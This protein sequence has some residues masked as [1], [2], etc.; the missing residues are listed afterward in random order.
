MNDCCFP[1]PSRMALILLGS[2]LSFLACKSQRDS[3][4]DEFWVVEHHP[5]RVQLV[6]DSLDLTYPGLEG[7]RSYVERQAWPQ[8]CR[9]LCD[10]YSALPETDWRISYTRN[11]PWDSQAP[12]AAQQ[13]LKDTIV[14]Q[15]RQGTLRRD[16]QQRIDWH[17]LGPAEDK[18]WAWFVN[19]FYFLRPIISAYVETQGDQYA[20]FADR[21]IRDWITQ[22]PMPSQKTGNATWRVLEVGLRMVQTWPYVFYSLR[23][24]E[25]FSVGSRMLFLASIVEHASYLRKHHWY[26]HNHS[27]MEMNGLATIALLW[28]E[29]Q[30][31]ELWYQHAETQILDDL[32]FLMYPDGAEIELSS[33]YHRVALLH[34]EDFFSL[35]QQA[36]KPTNATIEA[37]LENMWSYLAYT[38]RPNGKGL[39]NN[40]SDLDNNTPRLL[41]AAKT[42]QR[43]DWTYLMTQGK[44]GTQP[45]TEP[46]TYFE[47]A[48]H[49]ISRNNWSP[50]A[51]WAFFDVGCWGWSH[52]H[53]DKLHLSIHAYGRDLLVDGGRYWYKNPHGSDTEKGRSPHFWRGYFLHS[54]SHNTIL[55]DGQGQ[56]PPPERIKLE[57]PLASSLA[58]ITPTY[59]LAK[60]LHEEGYW[61]VEGEITHERTLVYLPDQAWL[62]IDR[63]QTD[64]ER[65]LEV[66]WHFHPDCRVEPSGSTFGSTD[67]GKGNLRIIPSEGREW[68]T[69]LIV[70]QE[71]PTIQGWYSERYNEKHPNPTVVYR[72]STTTATTF[73]W[74]LLPAKGSVGMA[75]LVLSPETDDRVTAH[76][77]FLESGASLNLTVDLVEG[78]V[79]FFD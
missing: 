3:P 52:Q 60:G 48:G 4:F 37:A 30:A 1:L 8:A 64:R 44:Q 69:D 42:Y 22:N 67:P 46:S 15:S 55:I 32:D 73:G 57:A 56:Q 40:D 68:S 49:F 11:L 75:S 19:R 20:E 53:E 43:P 36:G 38:A 59:S 72:G 77:R 27:V 62:V 17:D 34:F 2:L 50:E 21:T 66:L 65:E 29:F 47:W 78:T 33:T 41:V 9:A 79:V 74:L 70:G 35:S 26:H 61:G 7:V 5:D 39:L 6:F 23:S 28:P 25:R 71:T 45:A 10:Y 76:V 12:S 14:N 16:E 18:E 58:R 31:S 51:H 54:A 63:I 13:V 24:S